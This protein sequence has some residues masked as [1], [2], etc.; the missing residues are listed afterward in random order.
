MLARAS[1][2][3]TAG[4]SG[5]SGPGVGRVLP[6]EL[7]RAHVLNEPPCIHVQT[8][9]ALCKL[10]DQKPSISKRQKMYLAWCLQPPTKMLLV[11]PSC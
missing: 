7:E 5:P 2:E 6:N 9:V 3:S 10:N 8:C 1:C 4:P 11:L